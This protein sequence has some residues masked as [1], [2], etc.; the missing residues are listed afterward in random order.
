[1]STRSHTGA[2]GRLRLVNRILIPVAAL[3]L[4][5]TG[6]TGNNEPGEN[7]KT[8][9]TAWVSRVWSNSSDNFAAFMKEHSDIVVKTEVIDT[10][11]ILQ[12]LLRAAD[13]GQPLPDIIQDDTF[14][15]EAFNDAGLVIPLDDYVE[16]FKAD[17]STEFGK[18]LPIV[19]SE[20]TIDGKIL[21]VANAANMDVLYYN[22][23]WFKEAGV[24]LP[25]KTYDEIYDAGLALLKARPGSIPMS[26][27]AVAGDGVT[28]LKTV[29]IGA[30][31]PF[32]GATPDLHSS[33][34]QYTLELFQKMQRAG[35]LPSEAIAWGEAEA[36]GAFISGAGMIIDGFTTAG[37]FISVDGFDFGEDWEQTLMPIDTGQGDEGARPTSSRSWSITTGS[38]NPEAAWEV[39]RYTTTPEFL[40][41]QVTQGGVPPRNTEALDS[42]DVAAYW[43]FFT[44]E[45]K[46]GYLASV[47][48]PSAL[49]A[50]DVEQILEQ[51]WGEIVTGVEITPAELADKYQPQ[52]DA[53]K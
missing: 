39:L 32:D 50:G 9:I 29:L 36:R 27:Q 46:Q 51:L 40:I 41:P 33:G 30:G 37:D 22:V 31:V 49:N 42:P 43:P 17:D 52:L 20:P 12:R 25:L 35:M 44:E 26:I 1:M 14:M 2:F 18:V 28:G 34:A 8:T 47:S 7:G 45:V 5:L 15:L 48:G 24:E 23:P 53:L 11:D 19:W 6:C 21:G 10:D 16:A 3:S 38:K 4:L 13:A